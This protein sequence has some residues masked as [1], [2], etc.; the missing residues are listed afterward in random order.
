MTFPA[1]FFRVVAPMLLGDRSAAEVERELGPC[2]SGTDALA[3]Y[4]VLARRDVESVLERLF[5]ATRA[6]ARRARS[7]L[8]EELVG[9]YV[10]AH[11]STHWEPNRFAA[12][13]PD[14]VARR[15]VERGDVP[16][17]LEEVADFEYARF[18]VTRSETRE[19]VLRQYEH[20]VRP[21]VQDPTG[22]MPRPRPIVLAIF[23]DDRARPASCELGIEEIAAIARRQGRS[24]GFP[25]A[26]ELVEA[27]ERRLLALGLL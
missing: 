19:P 27:A 26:P 12:A 23:R 21:F 1:D 4:A 15:R 8:W 14:F 24:V 11:R 13:F 7:G 5:V 3:F 18:E 22:P 2:P 6:G 10:R 17:S 16:H 9:G 20:D 25:V